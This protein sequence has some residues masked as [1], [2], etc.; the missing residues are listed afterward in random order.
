MLLKSEALGLG[1]LHLPSLDRRKSL[2]KGDPFDQFWRRPGPRGLHQ[3]ENERS[4]RCV[5]DPRMGSGLE[6][7]P[8]RP[9]PVFD[10][11]QPTR[12]HKRKQRLEASLCRLIL[13]RRVID[14]Q[15]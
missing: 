8:M 10:Y 15:I 11:V 9:C 3:I 2:E 7:G 13:M 5:I 14:Y 4:K 6:F 1:D 12:F